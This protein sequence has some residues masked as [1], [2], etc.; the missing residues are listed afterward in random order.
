MS[1]LV[2]T[3]G[4]RWAAAA[5][6]GV[7][8]SCGAASL[9]ETLMPVESGDAAEPSA[10]RT[11]ARLKGDPALPHSVTPTVTRPALLPSG[12]ELLGELGRGG[13]GVVYK[14]QHLALNRVVAFKMILSGDH[15]GAK[16][17]ERFRRR[18]P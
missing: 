4:H 10:I 8:P 18:T 3:N 11:D 7:C 6:T 12:Y 17:R 16:E 13:M 14:A 1:L 2:C 15:A 9:T 5:P